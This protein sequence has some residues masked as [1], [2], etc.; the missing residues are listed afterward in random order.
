ML[1][2]RGTYAL[3]E[4][5]FKRAVLLGFMHF[6]EERHSDPDVLDYVHSDVLDMVVSHLDGVFAQRDSGVSDAMELLDYDR[7]RGRVCANSQLRVWIKQRFDA[8]DL[9]QIPR[10]KIVYLK[11][12]A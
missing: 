8:L 6:R 4:A 11:E 7:N 5:T 10:G 1:V 12:V 9:S 3:L 2:T